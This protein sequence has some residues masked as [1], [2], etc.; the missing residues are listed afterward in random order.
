[1]NPKTN[2][3]LSELNEQL[4]FINLE[5]DNRIE[6]CEKAIE[7]ILVAVQKLKIIF[8]KENLKSEE[9]EIE[10]FK[11]VK[12]KFTS[13]LIY[14]N[15][16]YK[17]EAQMPYGGERILKKYLNNE[18]DKIKR[19]FYNNHDFNKYHRT[20][21]N[22]LDNKYYVRGKID[23]KLAVDSFFFEADHS[24][25][26]SHDFKLAK[27]L[28]HDLVQV[29]IEDRLRDIDYKTQKE[30]SQREPNAKLIWTAPKVS[31]I[32]MIYALHSEGVFN[33]GVADI[34]D[35]VENFEK[36]FN[37]DLGQYRRTFLEIRARKSDR[38]KFLQSL[39]D[40]LEKRMV[41]I[42]ETI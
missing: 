18:L 25:S 15:I 24:F 27:I 1:M 37:I 20:G 10:F 39:K 16:I 23:I 14:Y 30:K 13:K 21:G 2:N 26:T 8:N 9:R 35:I 36:N 7:L 6:R 4:N 40:T 34:K 12:P 17:I 29:Y 31:L 28:A 11:N 42:D 22:Y 41:N 32:E 38:P 5:I 33:N 3:L 19:Y